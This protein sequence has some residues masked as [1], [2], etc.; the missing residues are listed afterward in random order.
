MIG[1]KLGFCGH[2]VDA[3]FLPLPGGCALVQP[4]FRFN[5]VQPGRAR[6]PRWLNMLVR[7]AG[8]T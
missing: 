6:P 4:F 3:E 8:M 1:A 7:R 2:G 5:A